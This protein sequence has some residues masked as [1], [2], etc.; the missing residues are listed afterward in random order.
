M[1]KNKW[2][3]EN[4]DA[5]SKRVGWISGTEHARAIY[6]GVYSGVQKSETKSWSFRFLCMLKW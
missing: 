3:G 4:V 5:E 6:A 1:N 2:C